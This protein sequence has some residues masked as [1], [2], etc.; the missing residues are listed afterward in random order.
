[1]WEPTLLCRRGS[2]TYTNYPVLALLS[3]ALRL[4][5]YE[6]S[7]KQRKN[8]KYTVNI[9]IELSLPSMASLILFYGFHKVSTAS[10]IRHYAKAEF[11]HP[12][13]E[14]HTN[15]AIPLPFHQPG[16]SSCHAFFEMLWQAFIGTST[17]KDTVFPRSNN[18]AKP[19]PC[20]IS[21]HV[22]RAIATIISSRPED[23]FDCT[24]EMVRGT[25]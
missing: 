20:I 3:V 7:H 13:A 10:Q 12:I 16:R 25:W 4:A 17:C 22:F 19:R 8:Y 2:P 11:S 5:D 21:K 15:G 23:E 1:M 18:F 6:S 24:G 14:S 9:E